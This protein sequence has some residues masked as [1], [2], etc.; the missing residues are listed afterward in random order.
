MPKK[1]P[2]K[3]ARALLFLGDSVTTDHI[4]P[5]GAIALDSPAARY[6]IKRGVEPKDFNSY[7]SRRGNDDVMARGT[8]GNRRLFNKLLGK[9]GPKTRHFPSDEEMYIYDCAARYREE[10]VPLIIIAG[11]EYGSGSSRDWGAKGPFLLGIKAVIAES[12]E[13]IHRTNLVGMGIVP[14]VFLPGENA[15][16]LGLDGHEKYTIDIPDKC[17]PGQKVPVT[18]DNGKKFE[19]IVRFDTEVDILYYTHGGIL[20][21]MVRKMAQ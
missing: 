18:L 13:R 21:Y 3:D 16:S 10:G 19:L 11:K 2:I 1:K 9:A 15:K 7:G 14:L 6:L 5:A 17:E 4:S 12:F 8:F 20:N